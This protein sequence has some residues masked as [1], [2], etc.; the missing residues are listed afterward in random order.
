MRAHARDGVDTTTTVIVVMV[1][2][3]VVAVMVIRTVIALMV[4]SI[5]VEEEEYGCQ[6][7]NHCLKSSTIPPN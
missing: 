3:T 6:K 2:R 7:G 1:V 5:V 4:I